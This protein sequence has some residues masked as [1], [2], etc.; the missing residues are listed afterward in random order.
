MMN[1]VKPRLNVADQALETAFG[2]RE[3]MRMSQDVT[4]RGDGAVEAAKLRDISRACY[5]FAAEAT[6]ARI[7]IEK[8]KIKIVKLQEQLSELQKQK[9]K[10]K[11]KS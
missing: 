1:K 10:R 9:R 8:Y 7:Q 5:L 2:M 3:R 4:L 11:R 6:D